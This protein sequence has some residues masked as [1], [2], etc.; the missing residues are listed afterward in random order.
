MSL[1]TGS[2]TMRNQT[3]T[4]DSD[5]VVSGSYSTSPGPSDLDTSSKTATAGM[6]IHPSVSSQPTTISGFINTLSPTAGLAQEDGTSLPSGLGLQRSSSTVATSSE[7]TAQG[8]AQILKSGAGNVT[9]SPSSLGSTIS[10][11]SLGIPISTKIAAVEDT[12]SGSSRSLFSSS[13]QTEATVV[14]ETNAVGVTV[15]GTVGTTSTRERDLL[16]DRINNG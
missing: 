2:L 13:R 8:D 15:T 3:T 9:V 14:T 16:Y 10:I 4:I 5:A 1:T 6:L 7:L 11:H 12:S